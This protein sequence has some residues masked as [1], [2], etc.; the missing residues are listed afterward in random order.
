MEQPPGRRHLLILRH[1]AASHRVGGS[2]HQRPLSTSGVRELP[3]LRA[4]LVPRAAGIRSVLVSSALRAVAT[5]E[6]IAPVLPAAAS[7][8][9]DDA[10]YGAGSSTWI[11]RCRQLEASIPAVLLIGHNPGLEGVVHE[12]APAADPRAPT[13]LA[14][15]L[16]PAGLVK[17]RVEVPW[18]ELG[19]ASCTVEEVRHPTVR[20]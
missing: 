13:P 9:C 18:W 8:A 12:L 20:P 1:A 15:G 3:A 16:A 19:Y 17:L 6:G 10:L 11:E 4:W 2:D 7:I 5:L 14:R